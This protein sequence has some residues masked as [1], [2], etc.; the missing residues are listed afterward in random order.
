MHFHKH[1]LETLFRNTPGHLFNPTKFCLQEQLKDQN[2]VVLHRIFSYQ[3]NLTTRQPSKTLTSE[4]D[5]ED[6]NMYTTHAKQMRKVCRCIKCK[7]QRFTSQKLKV[8]K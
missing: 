5:V 4:F 7:A 6:S 2:L 8:S 3:N 1:L